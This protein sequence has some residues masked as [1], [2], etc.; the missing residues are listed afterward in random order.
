[1]Y[2]G[3]VALKRGL[4]LSLAGNSLRGIDICGQQVCLYELNSSSV[5]LGVCL[6]WTFS[7]NTEHSVSA[8]TNARLFV[9]SE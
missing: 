1:M 6:E 8:K 3:P 7:P 2:P 4:L 9:L 5:Q